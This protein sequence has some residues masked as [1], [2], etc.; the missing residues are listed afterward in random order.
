MKS[1]HSK[2]DL[3]IHKEW[4]VFSRRG[5]AFCHSR[6]TGVGVVRQKTHGRTQTRT[7]GTH[8]AIIGG[9]DISAKR[10]GCNTDNA[11]SEVV[12]QPAPRAPLT[13]KL[14][15]FSTKANTGTFQAHG[16][17]RQQCPP[18]LQQLPASLTATRMRPR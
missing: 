12:W 2:T 10:C 18:Q 17:Q 14:A 7:R 3:A 11:S 4:R 5:S 15:M 16:D 9:D 8:N 13:L 6:R 1:N